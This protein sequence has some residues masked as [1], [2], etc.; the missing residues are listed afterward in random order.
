MYAARNGIQRAYENN[1]RNIIGN[2]RMGDRIN[3]YAAAMY[4]K[5]RYCRTQCPEYR[6]LAKMVMPEIWHGKRANCYAE[7][8]AYKRQ[9]PPERK[10]TA[11]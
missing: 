7:Q 8:Y 3:R 10:F 11:I 2:K 5:H 9:R 1:E 4:K 6:Y